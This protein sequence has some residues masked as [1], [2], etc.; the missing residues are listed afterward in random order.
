[1]LHHSSSV[2]EPGRAVGLARRVSTV[3]P[4][5][6]SRRGGAGALYCRALRRRRGEEPVQNHRID[7]VPQRAM[8][9]AA[10]YTA[11]FGRG[12]C[13]SQRCRTTKLR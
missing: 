12:C 5:S 7:G 1:M 10:D 2:S 8:P 3:V 13:V 9:T 6:S 4:S 11:F